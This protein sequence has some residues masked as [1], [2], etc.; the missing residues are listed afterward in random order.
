MVVELPGKPETRREML[1][2]PLDPELF[3]RIMA[4]VDHV[5]PSFDGIKVGVMS[6]LPRDI[7]IQ[8]RPDSFAD[9]AS[10]PPGDDAD[11]RAAIRPAGDQFAPG[12]DALVE[13]LNEV[14]PRKVEC[15]PDTDRDSPILSESASH[16]ESEEPGQGRVI[17]QLG[18]NVERNVSTVERKVVPEEN[19]EPPVPSFSDRDIAVPEE[20]VMDQ[21]ESRPSRPGGRRID[22]PL[23]HIDRRNDSVNCTPVGDL[24][25]IHRI[26]LVGNFA[27]PEEGVEVS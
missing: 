26:R 7:C 8:P 3:G 18:V 1:C 22:G 24:K 2:Q 4:G 14:S 15:A 19:L 10:G 23:R 5:D 12:A 21:D 25:P 11:S 9:H 6:P 17:T 20:P 16:F 27:Q 13:A